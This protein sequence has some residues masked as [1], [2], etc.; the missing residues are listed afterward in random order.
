M[1]MAFAVYHPF[2]SYSHAGKAS[3]TYEQNLPTIFTDDIRTANSP[4]KNRPDDTA[5]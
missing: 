4:S 5:R 3:K 1:R 2:Q